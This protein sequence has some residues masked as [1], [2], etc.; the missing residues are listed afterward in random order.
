MSSTT[1]SAKFSSQQL[2]GPRGLT[3]DPVFGFRRHSSLIVMIHVFGHD[4]KEVR[5]V[6]HGARRS[7][8]VD[9]LELPLHA[10]GLKVRRGA[11]S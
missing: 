8:S 4:G 7:E 5:R 1:T 2:G 9:E 10:T 6:C 3:A 11:S